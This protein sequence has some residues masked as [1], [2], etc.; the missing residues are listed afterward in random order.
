LLVID[1]QKA[2]RLALWCAILPSP[3]K[4]SLIKISFT[5]EVKISGV[6]PKQ[7][8]LHVIQDEYHR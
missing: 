4:I 1:Q 6:T 2:E 3:N 7:A 5:Q 8:Q